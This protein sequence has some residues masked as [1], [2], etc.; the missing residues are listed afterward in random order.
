MNTYM[1]LDCINLND[2]MW[3]CSFESWPSAES[4]SGSDYLAPVLHTS[5]SMSLIY[6]GINVSSRRMTGSPVQRTLSTVVDMTAMFSCVAGGN[7]V[8]HALVSEMDVQPASKF[9]G[10]NFQYDFRMSDRIF[11]VP[12]VLP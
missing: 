3:P 2:K 5:D 9:G 10:V 4:Q 8:P 11:V 12:S 7:V 1:T 6:K